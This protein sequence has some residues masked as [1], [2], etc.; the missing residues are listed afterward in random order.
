MA[1]GH[2]QP[3]QIL[4]TV[5]DEARIGHDHVDSGRGLVAEGDTEID[6]QPLTAVVVKVEVHADFIRPTQRQEQEFLGIGLEGF[7][8]H[9]L[10]R[11]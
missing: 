4:P 7:F 9:G 6:H 2:H 1:V 10:L 5:L 3:D 11:R 8:Q